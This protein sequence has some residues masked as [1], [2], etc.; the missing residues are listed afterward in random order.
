MKSFSLGTTREVRQNR[1]Q[2]D[3]QQASI[4]LR[5]ARVADATELAE[6]MVKGLSSRLHALGPEVVVIL[7][8]QM[9]TSK[10]C[11]CIV[12]ERHGKVV[13]YIAALSTREFYREFLLHKGFI[14]ALIALPRLFKPANLHT[15]VRSITYFPRSPHED[16]E[17]ELVSL[18]VGEGAQRCGVGAALFERLVEELR[19][20]EVRAFKAC[21]STENDAANALYRRQKCRLIRQEPFY[22]DNQINVYVY[23]LV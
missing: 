4:E 23:E 20:K 10:Y 22:R 21:T 8:R 11:L 2:V 1:R 14:C 19:L 17:T 5:S 9:I 18:V 6:L 16:P 12:A 3:P 13:G 7:H 15:A